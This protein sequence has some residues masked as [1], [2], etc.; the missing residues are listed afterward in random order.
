[1]H[2]CRSDLTV[3]ASPPSSPRKSPL[4][5]ETR[6]VYESPSSSPEKESAR[7]HIHQTFANF[8]FVPAD[9][10]RQNFLHSRNLNQASPAPR[11]KRSK[12]TIFPKDHDQS[13]V[14][15]RQ[16]GRRARQPEAAGR[17]ATRRNKRHTRPFVKSWNKRNAARAREALPTPRFEAL[18][19]LDD[20][21][22]P[23]SKGKFTFANFR[24]TSATQ[25]SKSSIKQLSF[26]PLSA[27][28]L[29]D[30]RH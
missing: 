21:G 5:G 1:M 7:E 27:S 25:R 4:D 20:V 11:R 26:Q 23:P 22:T 10:P 13:H 6:I 30:G 24:F 12:R 2:R 16:L 8:A 15:D 28:S 9:R 3:F 19:S 17:R 29:S 18:D 14:D